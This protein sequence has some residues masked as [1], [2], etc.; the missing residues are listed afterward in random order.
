[1]WRKPPDR[2]PRLLALGRAILRAPA[3]V[4]MGRARAMIIIAE[5]I[6]GFILVAALVNL[7]RAKP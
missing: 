4:P 1:M 5:I 3:R 6:G 2:Q 7:A